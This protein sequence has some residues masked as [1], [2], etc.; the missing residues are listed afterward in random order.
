MSAD[1]EGLRSDGGAR[2]VADAKNAF[3]A[4]VAERSKTLRQ[5][6]GRDL[7]AHR[8]THSRRPHPVHNGYTS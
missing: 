6:E 4:I 8:A 2:T 5:D 1:R 3:D 7:L